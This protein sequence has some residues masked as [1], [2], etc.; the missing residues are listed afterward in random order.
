VL[1]WCAL[2]SGLYSAEFAL[3]DWEAKAFP[4]IPLLS[5]YQWSVGPGGV[6]ALHCSS[7]ASAS[8]L[9]HKEPFDPWKFSRLKFQWQADQLIPGANPRKKSGDDYALRIY[10]I[11]PRKPGLM[12]RLG[13]VFAGQALPHSSLVYVWANQDLPRKAF[14]NP[15][16]SRVMM[17][18]LR[19]PKDL[20]QWQAEDV[21]VLEDYRTAF[22]ADP[23]QGPAQLAIMCDS[24]NSGL[25]SSGW[26][27]SLEAR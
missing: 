3:S 2:P 5:L 17:L 11:F 12:S 10:I 19:G 14:P 7:Q 25:V 18:P 23:P 26:I 16:T 24:D 9:V 8:A 15:Y 22:G 20:G 27:G 6:A 1:F 4:K 13:Q 21:D